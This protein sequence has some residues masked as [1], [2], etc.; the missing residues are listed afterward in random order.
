VYLYECLAVYH[1]Y[2]YFFTKIY[3]ING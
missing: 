1:V 3:M 2:I